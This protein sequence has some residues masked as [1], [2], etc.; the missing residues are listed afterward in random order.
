MAPRPQR[1]DAAEYYFTYIDRV[2]DGDIVAQ[3]ADQGRDVAAELR[4]IPEARSLLRYAADK[5]TLRDV[6]NHLTDTER[7]FLMRAFWVARG[8]DTPLPSFDQH[9]A[10]AAAHADARSWPDLVD[11]FAAARAGNA[12]FFRSLP[13]EA[14]NRRGIAS[15][16]PFTVLSLA[17]LCVGHVAHHMAIV[18]ER[19]L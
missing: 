4:A 12:A 17:F 10:V 11:D 13:A 6:V 8:F 3:L 2:P 7:L 1:G 19:Y 9:V 18:R 5:W 14:W 16:N 15:D